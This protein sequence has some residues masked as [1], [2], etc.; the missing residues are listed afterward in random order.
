MNLFFQSPSWVLS[1]LII[2]VLSVGVSLWLLYEMR[3]HLHPEHQRKSHDVVGFTFSIVGVL[4]SVILGFTVVNAQDR[5]NETIRSVRSEAIT[6]ADLYRE[7]S[8]FDPN[9]RDQIRSALREYVHYV[10]DKEW[11]M[12]GTNMLH[13]EVYAIIEKIWQC[14]YSIDLSSERTKAWYGDSIV[15]LNELLDARLSRQ[16]NAESHLGS[17]MWSLL[18]LGGILTASFMYFFGLESLRSQMI[19]TALLVAYVAFMLHLVYSLDNVFKGPEGI[20]PT[21]L[22]QVLTL[23]DLWDKS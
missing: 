2:I 20:K 6:I 18:I 7:A 22:E 16:F 21:A 11:S 5:Y 1:C 3:K 9:S 19:I 4:Y 8:L 12:E 13:P 14:Y 17:M 15:K 23:F 10:I